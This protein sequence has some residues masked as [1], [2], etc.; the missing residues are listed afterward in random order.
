[1]KVLA[2]QEILIKNAFVKLSL[3]NCRNS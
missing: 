1:M 3:N 2:L